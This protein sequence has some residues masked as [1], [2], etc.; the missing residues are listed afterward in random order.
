[1]ADPRISWFALS[2]DGSRAA[3]ITQESVWLADVARPEDAALIHIFPDDLLAIPTVA[4]SSDGN[5][6]IVGGFGVNGDI[7]AANLPYV[8]GLK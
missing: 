5:R 7:T 4:F 3:W 2:P 1:M 6:L 8:F